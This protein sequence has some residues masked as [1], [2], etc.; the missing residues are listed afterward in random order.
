MELERSQSLIL[1]NLQ[2]LNIRL[3][4]LLILK[5][6]CR[7]AGLRTFQILEQV[8]TVKYYLIIP[9][10]VR[11]HDYSLI[12]FT[13]KIFINNCHFIPLLFPRTSLKNKIAT[14]LVFLES[15][16]Q[17]IPTSKIG[18]DKLVKFM[19]ILYADLHA[20]TDKMFLNVKYK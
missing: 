12:I 15:Y 10:I 13:I 11:S 9:I 19:V 1:C 2:A 18:V 4:C 17:S 3:H 14:H 7:R 8:S 6:H 20:S 16:G 5:L